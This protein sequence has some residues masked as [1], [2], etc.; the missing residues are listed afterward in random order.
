MCTESTYIYRGEIGPRT[1]VTLPGVTTHYSHIRDHT[2]LMVGYHI[3]LGKNILYN[4]IVYTVLRNTNLNRDPSR[5]GPR[6][7]ALNCRL[8]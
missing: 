7:P 4:F 5:P 8:K 6:L 3:M 1:R 2:K